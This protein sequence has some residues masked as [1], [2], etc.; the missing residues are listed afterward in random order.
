[1][2]EEAKSKSSAREEKEMDQDET[3]NG[4]TDSPTSSSLLHWQEMKSKMKH[5]WETLKSTSKEM[6]TKVKNK[7]EQIVASLPDSVVRATRKSPSYVDIPS[8][9]IGS[10]ATGVAFVLV[11]VLFPNNNRSSR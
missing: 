1:L 10:A 11:M 3:K 7:T 5:G 2:E 6:M 9:I 4:T 8:T